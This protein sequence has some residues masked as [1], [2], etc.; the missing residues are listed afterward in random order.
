MRHV[1][2]KVADNQHRLGCV[3]SAILSD[4]FTSR[5]LQAELAT[6]YEGGCTNASRRFQGKRRC[7]MPTTRHGSAKS[8]SPI[9]LI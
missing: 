5:M 4:G 8:R 7:S 9:V 1:L 3:V 6:L 2:I